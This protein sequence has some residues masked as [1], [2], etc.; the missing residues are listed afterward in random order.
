MY[1][2]RVQTILA[3]T[4]IHDLTWLHES[5]K[6]LSYLSVKTQQT[7]TFTTDF[8]KINNVQNALNLSL[9][10]DCYYQTSYRPKFGYWIYKYIKLIWPAISW[11]LFQDLRWYSMICAGWT[12]T[13]RTDCSLRQFTVTAFLPV[14]LAQSFLHN[15]EYWVAYVQAIRICTH[16]IF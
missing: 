2:F 11:D 6:L 16:N 3:T 7:N 8:I 5:S 1:S 10:L 15:S 9:L 13:C 12:F 14:S 4:I